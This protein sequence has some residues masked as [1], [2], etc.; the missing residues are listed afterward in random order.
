M[1]LRKATPHQ[2]GGQVIHS[3]FQLPGRLAVRRHDGRPHLLTDD[4]HP[5]AGL[6]AIIVGDGDRHPIGSP[7]RTRRHI[8]LTRQ[9]ACLTQLGSAHQPVYAHEWLTDEGRKWCQHGAWAAARVAGSDRLRLRV[10]P[11]AGDRYGKLLPGRRNIWRCLYSRR[12]G[13]DRLTEPRHHRFCRLRR[14]QRAVRTGG[15]A[16]RLRYRH[17][18][19]HGSV[20]LGRPIHRGGIMPCRHWGLG[21]YRHPGRPRLSPTLLSTGGRPLHAAHGLRCARR[22][23]RPVWRCLRPTGRAAG[24]R[25]T[26]LHHHFTDLTSLQQ[27]GQRTGHQGCAAGGLAAVLARAND[28]SG[29]PGLGR[30]RCGAGWL[31]TPAIGARRLRR[32]FRQRS[33]RAVGHRV[34]QLSRDCHQYGLRNRD[35]PACGDLRQA[36]ILLDTVSRREHRLGAWPVRRRDGT[37]R[38]VCVYAGRHITTPDGRCCEPFGRDGVGNC[39]NRTLATGLRRTLPPLRLG[40]GP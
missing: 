27:L 10:R 38:N 5:D 32:R 18:H 11:P 2:G 40:H 29:Q 33:R 3:A 37:G 35:L 21:R 36:V 6:P 15:R 13:P 34:Q 16:H 8:P 26:S 31:R 22:H 4:R 19:Q 24:V 12:G 30:F 39:C 23:S 20:V 14:P 7:C 25:P 17:P 9:V 1:R 28:A